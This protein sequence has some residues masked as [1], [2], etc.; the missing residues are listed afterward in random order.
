MNI[1]DVKHHVMF[2]LS[3]TNLGMW[4]S[5]S[6]MVVAS[7]LP[8]VVEILLPIIT[9]VL[10]TAFLRLRE[11]HRAEVRARQELE[12]DKEKHLLE[13]EILRNQHKND[14]QDEHNV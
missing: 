1:P 11:D 12:Q 9:T 2:Y 13:L 5:S 3:H 10:L 6:L 7:F 4:L 14:N 8:H